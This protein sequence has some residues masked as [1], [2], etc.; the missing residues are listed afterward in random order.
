LPPLGIWSWGLIQGMGK[1]VI[2]LT[3]TNTTS[4][5]RMWLAKLHE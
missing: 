1:G 5:G 4:F 2:Y 3:Y